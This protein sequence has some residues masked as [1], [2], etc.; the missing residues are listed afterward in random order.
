MHE[1]NHNL[2]SEQVQLYIF[3]SDLKK[4]NEVKLN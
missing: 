3:I 1:I 4:K 2:S